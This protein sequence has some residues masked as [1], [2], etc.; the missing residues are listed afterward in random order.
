MEKIWWG[1]GGVF[2]AENSGIWMAGTRFFGDF[3]PRN[4]AGRW[5]GPPLERGEHGIWDLEP[6]MRYLGGPENWVFGPKMALLLG[7]MMRVFF[8]CLHPIFAE[9]L[10]V[11]PVF[12][13]GVCL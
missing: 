12:L 1:L 8:S 7:T 6:T 11:N 10:G 13:L 2:H 9:T 3:T 5:P 4:E